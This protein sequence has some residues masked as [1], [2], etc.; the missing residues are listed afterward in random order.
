MTDHRPTVITAP[1]VDAPAKPVGR[2]G[3]WRQQ[4]T[5]KAAD[6]ANRLAEATDR[7]NAAADRAARLRA[8]QQPTTQ[9]TDRTDADI[10]PIPNRLT[11]AGIWADRTFGAMPLIAPL[12]V[13]GYYTMKVFTGDPISAHVLI[14]FLAACALEG[15]VWKLAR[16]YEVTLVAGD[17]T[18]GLRFGIGIYLALISGLIYW[19]ALHEAKAQGRTELGEDALP[20][21]G[22]AVMSALGVYIWARRARWVR[23]REL[24]AAGRVDTQAPKFAALAW[25]LCPIE[26]PL[27]LRHAVKYRI[28]S[29][30]VAVED[31]RLFVAAGRPAIWPPTDRNATAPT[32]RPTVA[33]HKP[34]D[35]TAPAVTDRPA[36]STAPTSAPTADR[37]ATKPTPAPPTDRRMVTTIPAPRPTLTQ[38]TAPTT[39]PRPAP[40][41]QNTDTDTDR[42]T[43]TTAAIENAATIRAMFGTTDRLKL[44]DVRNA[45][46]P[47]WSYD[48]ANPA[49]KAYLAGADQ[50]TDQPAAAN[51]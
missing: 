32:D 33:D 20:A 25:L 6:R 39:Q 31:R 28:Q 46:E 45:F 51:A 35:R 29:P 40:A 42:P 14:A 13:S 41:K 4:R 5:D 21:I 17:S 7:A 43:F 26:T 8:T 24:H 50:P 18:M 48:K 22:V 9:P 30:T 10:A 34:T 11:W 44:A 27:A 37:P 38:P 1:P 2:V 36:A 16:L 15:G 12:L 19:H 49:F 3:R 47:R 23:R